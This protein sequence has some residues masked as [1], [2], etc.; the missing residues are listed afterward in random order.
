V[1]AAPLLR[2]EEV[3]ERLKSHPAWTRQGNMLVRTFKLKDFR[4]ALSFVEKV[5]D[6]ADAQN[7]HPDVEIHWNTVT[8]KLW[9]HASGGVTERDFRLAAAIDEIAAGS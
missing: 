3:A 2:D 9:T 4:D 5:A 7:H 6:P 8:L 1:P